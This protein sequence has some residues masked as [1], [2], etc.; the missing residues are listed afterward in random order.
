MQGNFSH[1]TPAQFLERPLFP[2]AEGVHVHKQK[3]ADTTRLAVD[4]T[5]ARLLDSAGRSMR[6]GH[7]L[8]AADAVEL[9]QTGAELWKVALFGR[10]SL[11][12]NSIYKCTAPDGQM[13]CNRPEK[14]RKKNGRQQ[15]KAVEVGRRFTNESKNA[16]GTRWYAQ[17]RGKAH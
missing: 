16:A 7:S 10:W 15:H 12:S 9:V 3:I 11:T 8:R 17:R 6:R 5:G 14:E 4:V 1:L 2:A 13:I